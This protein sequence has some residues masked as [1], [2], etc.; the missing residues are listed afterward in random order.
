MAEKL[1]GSLNLAKLSNVGIMTIQGQ[2]CAK[3]C[4][5]IPIEENDIFIKVEEKTSRDGQKYTDKK[6]CIGIEIYSS[7]E[8]DP[9]GNTHYAKVSVSKDY[10]NSHTLE[11]VAARNKI[12]L[13]NLKPMQIPNSNQASTVDA[14]PAVPAYS[15][16]DDLPF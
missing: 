15:S 16:D 1:V 14:P 8:T 7:R 9:Y 3:K 12:Y 13:G 5:V 2:S 10:I 11:D 4:L 6:Y